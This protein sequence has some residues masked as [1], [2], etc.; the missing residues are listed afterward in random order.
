MI[1]PDHNSLVHTFR[2]KQDMQK[3]SVFKIEY[4]NNT[5]GNVRKKMGFNDKNSIDHI[6]NNSAIPATLYAIRDFPN[7]PPLLPQLQ[8][9][10]PMNRG[11]LIHTIVSELAKKPTQLHST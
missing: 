8:R 3:K 6:T 4:Q 7:P 11:T 2:S 5:S 1:Q 9:Q 10:S